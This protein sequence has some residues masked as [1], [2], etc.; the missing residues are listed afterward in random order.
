M[1]GEEF[2]ISSY[3]TIIIILKI[4]HGQNEKHTIKGKEIYIVQKY[5]CCKRQRTAVEVFQIRHWRNGARDGVWGGGGTERD[6]MEG[7]G[8]V[9][10]ST[11]G[12]PGWRYIQ[13]FFAISL[14]FNDFQIKT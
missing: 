7:L 12:K 11:V 8:K 14:S 9:L 3:Y 6:R 5:Q 2:A 1:L 13:N 4:K 10:L